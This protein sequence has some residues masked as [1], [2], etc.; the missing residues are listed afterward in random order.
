MG[1][2]PT[3]EQPDLTGFAANCSLRQISK[4]CREAEVAPVGVEPTIFRLK[5]GCSTNLAQEP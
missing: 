1:L 3:L 5:G 2:E 4:L